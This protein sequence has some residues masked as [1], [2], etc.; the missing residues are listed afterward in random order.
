[1]ISTFDKP[2]VIV[3]SNRR[4]FESFFDESLANRLTHLARWE[5]NSA[6]TL[7]PG[8]CRNISQADALITTWDSP[9]FFPEELLNWAPKLRMIAHCGGGVKTRFARPLFERLMITNA[10]G[11]MTRHVAELAVT[12]LLYFAR[13]VDRY[14]ELLRQPSNAIYEQ[15]HISGGGEQTILGREVGMIGYGRI[16]RAIA[17][18]L[19]PFGARL[20]VHDP[21]ANPADAPPFVRF[22]PLDDVLAT[23]HFLILAAGLTAETSGM[24]DRKRLQRLPRGAAVINVARGGIVDLEALTAMVLR[25]RLRCALDVTDPLEPLPVRHPL[26]RAEG[27]ILTPHVGAIS[28]SVRREITHVVVSDL[29][30]FFS[31]QPVENRVTLAMLDRM[32]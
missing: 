25:G 1:M 17:E 26:R 30:R 6:R 32:T 16:G 3:S 28:R 9:S 8:L 13:D 15:M 19:A 7:S 21:Y 5:R 23:S 29:E 14:R 27:A 4:L 31:G 20:L 24:L 11:P 18:L 2:A 22:A 12:F 10:A